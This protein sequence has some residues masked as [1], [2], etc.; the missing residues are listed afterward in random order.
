MKN[1]FY[2]AT[3]ILFVLS[4]FAGCSS[5]PEVVEETPAQK[6]AP[7]PTAAQEPV[8]EQVQAQPEPQ[9]ALETMFYFDYDDANVHPGD[10]SS[11]EAIAN[12]INDSAQVI[13]IEGHADERGTEAY[14]QDLGQRR[15]NAVRDLLVSM[16]VSSSQIETVSYGEKKPIELGSG[17]TVWQKNR[18]VEI[19]NI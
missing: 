16:G 5:T 2:S 4:F 13:R 12:H 15:A 19:K 8:Q 11:I 18:C 14:N 10:R 1:K 9:V 7:E 17:E 6:S 3:A